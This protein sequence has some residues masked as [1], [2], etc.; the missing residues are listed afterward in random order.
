[1]GH[2]VRT[3]KETKEYAKEEKENKLRIKKWDIIEK[4][5]TY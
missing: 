1:L 5:H 2:E 3:T 4:D